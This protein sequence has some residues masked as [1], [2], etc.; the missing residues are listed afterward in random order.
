[1]GAPSE[2]G[3]MGDPGPMGAPWDH[4]NKWGPWYLG[5]RGMTNEVL[6]AYEVG[7]SRLSCGPEMTIS[8]SAVPKIQRQL[9]RFF[10]V[11]N[12]GKSGKS[13][14]WAPGTKIKF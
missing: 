11:K 4:G 5:L 14:F 10:F 12:S 2:Y 1:M 7:A 13:F 8:N 6:A 9:T 3:T